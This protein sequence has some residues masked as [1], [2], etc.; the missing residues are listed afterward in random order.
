MHVHCVTIRSCT[1]SNQLPPTSESK[2]KVEPCKSK[3]PSTLYN[4]AQGE[5]VEIRHMRY[6]RDGRAKGG[7]SHSNDNCCLITDI[8]ADTVR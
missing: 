1:H 3:V 7:N 8:P 4:A 2:E 5:R 6:T